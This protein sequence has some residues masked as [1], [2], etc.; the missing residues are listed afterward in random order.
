ME[1]AVFELSRDQ[2][3]NLSRRHRAKRT[4]SGRNKGMERKIQDGLKRDQ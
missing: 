3:Q 1:K 4:A 2:G